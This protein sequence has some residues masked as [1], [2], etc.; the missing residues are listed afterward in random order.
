MSLTVAL[1]FDSRKAL[2]DGKYAVKV[3]VTGK[4]KGKWKQVYFPTGET[5]SPH[6]WQAIKDGKTRTEELRKKRKNIIA[7]ESRAA[8]IIKDTPFISLE[9]FS[10]IYNG[11]GPNRHLNIQD[12]YRTQIEKLKARGQYTTS[13]IYQSAA[14]MLKEKRGGEL[15]IDLIDKDFLSGLERELGLSASTI[16]IYF[17]TIRTIWNICIDRRIVNR[18]F[19]PFGRKGYRLPSSRSSKRAISEDD[20]NLLLK[21]RPTN[22]AEFAALQVWRVS[23]F[24]NGMNASDL[25][26]LRR[27]WI[28]GDVLTYVRK[29]TAST[30]R[31]QNKQVVVIRPELKKILAPGAGFVF[32]VL[33]GG[34]SPE[35]VRRKTAQ[36]IKI[37]NKYLV[38]IGERLDIP[39]RLTTYTARHTAATMLLRAGA[40]LI[41]IREA[42]GHANVSTTENYLASLNLDEQRKMTAKL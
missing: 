34:E 14:N 19:Y 22:P 17:R 2:K 24:C 23:Y 13:T 1:Y 38:R 40:D 28:S 30:E 32:G 15:T 3:R 7:K 42:L 31:M 5:L 4:D 18:D 8:D 37:T 11:A 29:K 12:L 36:W 25:A 20:K 9:T 16:G 10:I 21:Y 35:Q 41:Y 26:L 39:V 27:E 6:E 33:S